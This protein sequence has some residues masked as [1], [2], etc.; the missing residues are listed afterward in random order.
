M[1]GRLDVDSF[2]LGA[3]LISCLIFWGAVLFYRIRQRW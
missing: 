2:M 3:L 1:I